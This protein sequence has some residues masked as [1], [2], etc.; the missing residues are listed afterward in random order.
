ATIVPAPD[1]TFAWLFLTTPMPGASTIT[2]TVDGATV[3]AADGSL[4]DAAG[5]GTAGSR[6]VSSFTTVSEAFVP[7]ST[8][9]GAVLDA[10]RDLK[11]M[12]RD[13]VRNGPDD[14]LG[15]ADDVYL[16]P[17]GG[18]KVYV[19][20]HED[21]AVFTDANGAFSFTSMPSGNIKLVVDGRTASSAPAGL[22]Y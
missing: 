11:P 1:G 19:I 17:I 2:V 20:G 5:N 22:F 3:R 7:G 10:G 6:L 8:L 16:D 21:Q 18:A 15:T 9:S 14:V 12:T 4:L 13:D